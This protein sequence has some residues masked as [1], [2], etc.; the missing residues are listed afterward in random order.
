M[1]SITDMF[2]PDEKV[3]MKH[4]DFYTLLKEASRAEIIR[5]LAMCEGNPKKAGTIIKKLV[6]YQD[7]GKE[8]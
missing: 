4:S 8:V 2:T 3:T 6:K 1:N 5:D 7:G